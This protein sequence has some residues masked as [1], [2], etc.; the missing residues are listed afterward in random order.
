MHS[1]LLEDGTP[2]DPP[3]LKLRRVFCLFLE[4]ATGIINGHSIYNLMEILM[5]M[6]NGIVVFRDL[7]KMIQQA[8]LSLLCGVQTRAHLLSFLAMSKAEKRK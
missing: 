6:V 5:K 2:F 1:P 4:K 3:I 8:A 7:F